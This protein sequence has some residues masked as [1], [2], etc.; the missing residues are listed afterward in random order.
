M[1]R[2][3]YG[4]GSVLWSCGALYGEIVDYIYLVVYANEFEM[5]TLLH[6]NSYWTHIPSMIAMRYRIPY[7]LNEW[8]KRRI[9]IFVSQ[10]TAKCKLHMQIARSENIIANDVCMDVLRTTQNKIR[11]YSWNDQTTHTYTHMPFD[12]NMKTARRNTYLARKMITVD[13]M[14]GTLIIFN[15]IMYV[16]FLKLISIS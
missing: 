4:S 13:C 16:N 3:S 9:G 1:R 8:T 12:H 2:H 10:Q 14:L 5:T 11:P 7:T 15:A 6:E